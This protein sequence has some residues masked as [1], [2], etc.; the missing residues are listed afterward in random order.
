MTCKEA[1]WNSNQRFQTLQKETIE[2]MKAYTT[3][4]TIE[5][6]FGTENMMKLYGSASLLDDPTSAPERRAPEGNAT[7]KL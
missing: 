5:S 2:K 7:Q 3:P 1:K 4:T 6:F